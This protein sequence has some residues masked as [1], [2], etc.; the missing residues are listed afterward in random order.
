MVET[1]GYMGIVLALAFL[2][3]LAPS[4]LGQF[5]NST[6]LNALGLPTWSVSI[7]VLLAVFGF[8]Y[9]VARIFK[10]NV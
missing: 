1:K 5:A 8:L 10:I 3:A 9:L 7:I 2:G 6:W 4:I